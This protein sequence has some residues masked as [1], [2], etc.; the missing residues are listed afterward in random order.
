MPAMGRV[1]EID[2]PDR[3]AP[4]VPRWATQ[5][6]VGLLCGLGAIAGRLAL[7]LVVPGIG[8]YALV[9]PA[10]ILA[11]LFAHWPAGVLT[12]ALA[13]FYAWRTVLLGLAAPTP[14]TLSDPHG[15]IRTVVI[16][17]AA[18]ITIAIAEAFRQ[19]VRTAAAERDREIAD[20]D[21]FLA[22][23]DHRM[24]N[25]FA[26]VA[27]LLDMQARRA[28]HPA[29]ATALETAR[30][31]VESIAQAHRHL[32]RGSDQLGAVEMGDYLHQL[33]GALAEALFLSGRVTLVCD[34]AATQM[35]RDRAVSIGLVVNELVTNAAKHAFAD[36]ETGRIE[37]TLRAH[38]GGWT[39]V[40]ADNGVGL[41]AKPAP[42][43][44][45]GTRLI[46][47]FAR[48]AGGT[49]RTESGPDGTRVMLELTA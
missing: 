29:T 40:V 22:E 2:L 20:R 13:I 7:D 12:A 35:P 30:M 27:G 47:A 37:V 46:D 25:N 34:I 26:I 41:P 33:C 36:R 11:T 42:R 32:Y 19:A 49:L 5:L 44:S 18:G 16:A 3:L 10:L 39:L 1:G 28:E 45:L 4:G 9:F 14:T 17:A 24:K 23:F 38:A 48:Q 8:P 21:L 31:R 15:V 43:G 6:G